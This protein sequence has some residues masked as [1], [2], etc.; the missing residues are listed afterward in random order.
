M[1]KKIRTF[2]GTLRETYWFLPTV[3]TILAICLSFFT[4]WLDGMVRDGFLET[5]RF[6][7]GGAE[8]ARILLSTV[9]GS[10][11]TIA[12][13]TFSVTMVALSMAS[14]QLG[15]RL[16]NNFLRD[17]GNQVVLGTFVST[18]I[19][20]LLVL[21]AVRNIDSQA[22]V[23][24]ISVTVGIGLAL[25]SVGVLI[26]FFHH[27]ASSIHAEKVVASVGRD[28]QA[29]IEKL[30][31]EVEEGSFLERRLRNEG[32]IPEE[33]NTQAYVVPDP[34]SGYLQVVDYEGLLR[35]AEENDL[36]LSI[37]YRPRSFIPP[38]KGIVSVWPGQPVDEKL[39]EQ[40]G[41][42]FVIGAHLQW[43]QSVEY[44]VNQLV[45]IAVRALSPG[46]N[47]PFLAMD[48]V[49]QLGAALIHLAEKSVPSGYR[50]DKK[51]KLRLITSSIN[52]QTV[53]DLAFHQIRRYAVSSVAVTIRLLETIAA[54][55]GFVRTSDAREAIMRH[56][57][58]IKRSSKRTIAEEQDRQDVQDRYV[59]VLE[60]LG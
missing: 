20:C 58:M 1:K 57:E 43:S 51:G 2:L 38:G 8:G 28:L 27:V 50:Y 5:V 23:P 17:T 30:L 18:F 7:T 48:C 22:F 47:D 33:L 60:A 56:A 55:A 9:A 49:D 29:A 39:A 32:D 52:Y 44:A 24:H 41:K 25:A 26:Y 13:V 35:I 11:I 10:M 45:A 19:Y 15:P 21:R 16:L 3:M 53:M 59:S 31:S 12:G 14:S 54:V 46:I 4:V 42:T 6:Y 40:L 34:R 36:L 37:G